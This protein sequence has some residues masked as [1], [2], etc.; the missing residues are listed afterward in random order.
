MAPDVL[1]SN[2][3]MLVDTLW[4]MTEAGIARPTIF[5][6]LCKATTNWVQCYNPHNV[7]DTL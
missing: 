2:P 1:C 3:H 7:A 6:A 5:E 4:A